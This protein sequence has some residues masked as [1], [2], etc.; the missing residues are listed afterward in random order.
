MGQ[1]LSGFQRAMI[2][3]APM[4]VSEA[5]VYES[6]KNAKAILFAISI[7]NREPFRHVS[8]AIVV[9]G[10]PK[11]L[12]SR[13]IRDRSVYAAAAASIGCEAVTTIE[14]VSDQQDLYLLPI[15]M[16]RDIEAAKSKIGIVLEDEV[17]RFIIWTTNCRHHVKNTFLNAMNNEKWEFISKKAFFEFFD[18]LHH[19]D[20]CR[21]FVIVF[22]L[23]LSIFLFIYLV[24][25]LTVTSS[26]FSLSKLGKI[27]MILKIIFILLILQSRKNLAFFRNNQSSSR[28]LL[29]SFTERCLKGE[30]H[31]QVNR[32]H[33]KLFS[34]KP[35]WECYSQAV[36]GSQDINCVSSFGGKRIGRN[37][38]L[39]LVH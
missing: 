36:G 19:D 29:H 32:I 18:D 10:K 8:I 37:G 14:E 7:E 38:L 16:T 28:L 23:I 39:R 27:L 21:C 2:Y 26:S 17:K 35:I 6:L 12:I 9:D 1:V 22:S 20:V 34:T 15:W 30:M 24:F 5:V 11:Y 33:A 31:Q 13:R 3:H 4:S 25:I